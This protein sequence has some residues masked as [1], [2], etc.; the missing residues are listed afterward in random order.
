MNGRLLNLDQLE[1]TGPDEI[2]ETD[3]GLL[4]LWLDR[5]S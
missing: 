3:R 1:H 2:D 4:R 5:I